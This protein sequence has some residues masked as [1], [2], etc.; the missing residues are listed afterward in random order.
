MTDALDNVKPGETLSPEQRAALAK[1]NA[2]MSADAHR[3]AAEQME[4]D[5]QEG[6]GEPIVA[7]VA[8]SLKRK[9][10]IGDI[11]PPEEGTVS[12]STKGND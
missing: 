12:N 7:S 4:R 5:R 11:R 9:L 10:Q 6:R 8:D 2:D 1:S 3:Q